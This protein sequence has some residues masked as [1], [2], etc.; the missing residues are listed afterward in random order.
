MKRD[1]WESSSDEEEGDND[2]RNEDS[3]E[4]KRPLTAPANI[5]VGQVNLPQSRGSASLVFPKHNPLIQGC[6]SVYDCYERL[7]RLDE[8]TYGVVWKAKDLATSE[9]VALKQIKF[10]SEMVKEGFPVTALREISVLLAMSHE[11]VVTVREM[12]VGASFDKVFMVMEFMEMDL[13]EA[14]KRTGPAPFPQSELKNML[15]QIISATD[16]IHQ[17]WYLHRDMKTSNILV[18][19]SGKIAVC[20]FGLARKYQRPL[21][22]LTQLVI[23]L[24]YRPPELLFG[25]RVYGP[26]VDMWSIGCIF[27]ELIAKEAMIQGEGELDQMDKIFR[28]VGAPTE[29]NWPGYSKLPNAGIFR[30]KQTREQP[31]ISTRF[32]VNSPSGGKAFLDGNGFDLLKKLLTLDPTKRISAAQALKHPYFH[33]G[34]ARQTPNFFFDST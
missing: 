8:G 31:T 26:E 15:F 30:W 21:K 12:V 28:L 20:D 6:R 7:A 1:R 13:Q 17:K 32:P 24:W 18:H 4:R 2:N 5:A 16:H 34:V 3:D 29:Q 25:E 10:D 23:T 14:M 19:K 11:C 22:A 9:V 33:E 27:G